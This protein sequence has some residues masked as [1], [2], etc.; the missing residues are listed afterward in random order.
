MVVVATDLNSSGE[1][2]SVTSQVR[3]VEL[4]PVLTQQRKPRITIR[5]LHVI[6]GHPTGSSMIFARRES[7]SLK[8]AAIAVHQFFLL[9]R[10]SP[11][12]L[13]KELF[14]LRREIRDFEPHLIHAHYGTV[15]GLF[16]G[17]ATTLPLVVTYRGSDLNPCPTMNRCRSFVGRLFSQLAALR[18]SQTICVSK[19]LKD[20]LWWRR[21]RATVIAGG[22]NLNLFCPQPR[23]QA[24]TALG[25]LLEDKIVLFNAGRAPR[26]KRLDL[27]HAAI[28]EANKIAGKSEVKMVVLDGQI[29][30]DSIPLY[31]N[32][33]DCLL[34]TSDWE[35]SPYIVKEALS[36]NLPIVS[37]DV[38]DIADSL[39]GVTPSRIVPRDTHALATAVLRVLRLGCRSNGHLVTADLSD[40]KVAERIRSVY[41]RVLYG[42]SSTSRLSGAEQI[43][44]EHA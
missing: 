16:C 3:A 4:S 22:L 44:A 42:Q 9:S 21:S 2:A 32:A 33:A 10:T 15:T 43:R 28:R 24:R 41:E 8:L 38:G 36:C 12:R 17:L 40:E 11:L 39:Q 1:T 27:A 31:L 34:V 18:A 5:A 14:R 29:D 37:V 30:P 23:Y 20:R 7:M 35:G 19:Q 26:I 13:V 6:L 25:W